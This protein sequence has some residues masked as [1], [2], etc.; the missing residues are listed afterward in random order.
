MSDKEQLT[1]KQICEDYAN[2]V[3]DRQTVV[4]QLTDFQYVQDEPSDGYD[5]LTFMSDKSWANVERAVRQGKICDCIYE[6]V[7]K[8]RHPEYEPKDML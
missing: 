6:E 5:W 4:T 7:F 1:P 3:I 2:G 8:N